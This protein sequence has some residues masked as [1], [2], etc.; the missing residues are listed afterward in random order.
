MNKNCS[1]R[2]F[3]FLA[4]DVSLLCLSAKK[5]FD[6]LSCAVL[7][8]HFAPGG[9]WHWCENAALCL[10][11]VCL[12][13]AAELGLPCSGRAELTVEHLDMRKEVEQGDVSVGACLDRLV[14]LHAS[15]RGEGLCGFES[16][17]IRRM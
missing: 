15:F 14:Y 11:R 3:G 4:T 17:N 5:L 16:H 13:Q 7:G 2:V 6:A 10:A 8:S 12:T 1:C 9:T